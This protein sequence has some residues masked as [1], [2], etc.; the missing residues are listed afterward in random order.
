[1]KAARLLSILSRLQARG[2]ATARELAAL[3]EVSER[4]IYRDIDA[5]SAAGY[6]VYG[7]AGPGGGFRLL[8]VPT[9]RVTAL[10]TAEVEAL[11]L[12]GLPGPAAALGMG[13]AVEGA[14][15]KLLLRLSGSAQ[16][17]RLGA[18]FHLDTADWYRSAD[19]LPQLPLLARAVLDDQLISFAYASWTQK[20]DWVVAPLGLVLKGG[21]W[22]LIG[23]QGARA[24]TFRVGAMSALALS[25]EGF[26]RREDFDLAQWW[27]RSLEDFEARL[28]PF[29]ATLLLTQAGAQ[30]LA[31]QGSY[32]AKAIAAGTPDVLGLWVHMPVES[33]DQAARLILGLGDECLR[34]EPPDLCAAVC[35]LALR[36]ASLLSS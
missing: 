27:C 1:M 31:E 16:A 26:D 6:P 4:T 3:H 12:I 35:Q 29:R 34:V 33:T 2:T 10:A 15:D 14:R 24:L 17:E 32:A 25:G 7:D 20:R 11:L 8:D 9:Q 36:M 19:A 28:R 30:R 5:L 18:R 13:A 23:Q 22:Y 21:A